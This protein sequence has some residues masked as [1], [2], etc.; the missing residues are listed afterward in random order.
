[1]NVGVDTYSFHRLFGHLRRGEEPSN[2]SLENGGVAAVRLAVEL[3]VD[4]IAL[5]TCFL[6]PRDM[7]HLDELTTAAEGRMVVPSWGAPDGLAY[8]TAP[9]AFEDALAWLER[10]TALGA[11][12]MRIVLGGPRLRDLEPMAVRRPRVVPQLRTLAARA[13]DLGVRVAIENHGDIS[14][15]DLRSIVDD[16]GHPALGVCFDTANAIRVGDDPIAAAELLAPFTWML[17]LKDIEPIELVSDFVAGPKSVPYGS[18]IVPLAGTLAAMDS[19]IEAGAP[20]CI[21]LGQIADGTDEVEFVRSSVAW[22][23]SHVVR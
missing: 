21:E 22:L 18:G 9:A 23:R 17:H 15:A 11:P 6:T 3:D 16:V 1:M 20:V 2:A 12:I 7:L 13:Q 10:S 8:G 14:A 19:C 5:Q 4:T